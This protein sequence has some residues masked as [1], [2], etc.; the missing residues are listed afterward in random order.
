MLRLLDGRRDQLEADLV[1]ALMGEGPSPE[2]T[3]SLLRSQLEFW[4]PCGT[5][6]RR[7]LRGGGATRSVAGR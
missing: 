1:Q 5:T 7:S 4:L 2:H 3:I 6:T